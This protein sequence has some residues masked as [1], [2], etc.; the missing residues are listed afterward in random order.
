MLLPAPLAA[1]LL[2]LHLVALAALGPDQDSLPQ[3]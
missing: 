2:D 1:W 3:A